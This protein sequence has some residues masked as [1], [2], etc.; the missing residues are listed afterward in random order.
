MPAAFTTRP[1]AVRCFR[2][3]EEGRHRNGN[4]PAFGGAGAGLRFAAR[5]IAVVRTRFDVRTRLSARTLTVPPMRGRHDSGSATRRVKGGRRDRVIA[6][7]TALPDRG[8]SLALCPEDGSRRCPSRVTPRAGSHVGRART[9]QTAVLLRA[10][11]SAARFWM[12]SS[13]VIACQ[14]VERR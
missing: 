1:A 9:L 13:S 3:P 6:V 8:R 2:L 12:R 14:R 5:G 10:A 11:S 7:R 4:D